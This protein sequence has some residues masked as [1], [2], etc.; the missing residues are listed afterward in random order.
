MIKTQISLSLS[1]TLTLLISSVTVLQAETINNIQNLNI[2]QLK[3]VNISTHKNNTQKAVNSQ[4]QLTPIRTFQAHSKGIPS[5]AITQ[6]SKIMASASKDGMIKIWDLRNQ[7]IISTI[8]TERL[9]IYSI[10]ITPDATKLVAGGEKGIKIWD[11]KE[12]KLLRSL[13]SDKAFYSLAISPNG[14]TFVNSIYDKFR[15]RIE[16]RNLNDGQ[17][18]KSWNTKESSSVE[19]VYLSQD[20]STVLSNGYLDIGRNTKQVVEAWDI[21]TGNQLYTIYPSDNRQCKIL[22]QMATQSL[23]NVCKDG[24]KIFNLKTGSL[25]RNFSWQQEKGY[26]IPSASIQSNGK[27]LAYIHGYEFDDH[28]GSYMHIWDLNTGNKLK[29]LKGNIGEYVDEIFKERAKAEFINVNFTPDGTKLIAGYTSGAIQ[30][31]KVSGK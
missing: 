26:S 24:I 31:W 3:P 6:D 12:R 13:Y 10:A 22:T 23:I 4:F 14:K 19:Q 27:I 28:Y 29:E 18:I 8:Q 21:K 2:N 25:N 16:L 15:E 9:W 11:L 30:I 1:I 20:G 7:K 5:I 17:L